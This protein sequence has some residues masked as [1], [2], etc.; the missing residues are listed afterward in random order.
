M[1]GAARRSGQCSK[2]PRMDRR[3]R[4]ALGRGLRRSRGLAIDPHGVTIGVEVITCGRRLGTTPSIT[5][6]VRGRGSKFPRKIAIG[7]SSVTGPVWSKCLVRGPPRLRSLT[8][9]GVGAVNY[10][11]RRSDAG[12]ARLGRLLGPRATPRLWSSNDWRAQPSVSRLPDRGPLRG[13]IDVGS[14][15]AVGRGPREAMTLAAPPG[16]VAA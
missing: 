11:V 4:D 6:L 16:T 3:R 15:P 9:S 2:M 5:R 10:D 1:V 14:V 7:I 12:Y 8:R 13:D